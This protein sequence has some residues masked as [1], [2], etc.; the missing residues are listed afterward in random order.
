[1]KKQKKFKKMQMP[2]A[3]EGF[4]E[5]VGKRITLI[6]VSVVSIILAWVLIKAFLERS[7]YFRI[8]SVDAKGATE[9][10]LTGLRSDIL[11]QYKDINIF[12]VNLSAIVSS[13]EPKY[14]DASQIAVRRVLP[15][16][17]MIDLRFRKPVAL[18]SNGQ[19]YPIDREGGNIGQYKF[20]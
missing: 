9:S 18:L 12:K 7:D 6:I 2:K 1:M 13:I 4:K 3:L 17:L 10:S 15:D 16:K 5:Y 11:R 19:V 8:R 14:P 20:C